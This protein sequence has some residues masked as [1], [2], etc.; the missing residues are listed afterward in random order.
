MS[1]ALKAEMERN[2][3]ELVETYGVV[4]S[5]Q[6]LAR[7]K[8]QPSVESPRAIRLQDYPEEPTFKERRLQLESE[9]KKLDELWREACEYFS[10]MSPSTSKTVSIHVL[11]SIFN[12]K[13]I[14]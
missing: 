14:I 13:E 8:R 11:I 3:A 7:R 2:S 10:T 1:R 12:K 6:M 5:S 9:L 4:T